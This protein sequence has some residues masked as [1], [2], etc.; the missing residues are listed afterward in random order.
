MRP[1]PWSPSALE[2]FKNCPSQYEHRYVLK[3]LPPEERSDEQVYGEYVHEAFANRLRPI[4]QPLPP[5]VKAHEPFMQEL[6]AQEGWAFVEHKAALAKTAE[7][8]EWSDKDV[9]CRMIIDYL[10]VDA[11]ERHATIVDH[12]TG[13][14]H[15]KFNQLVIY[16]L[17]TFQEFSYVDEIEVMFYWTKNRTTTRKTWKREQA[18]QLWKELAGDLRQYR[19][20]FRTGIWQVRPSGLCGGWCPVVGC[21]YW[22]PKR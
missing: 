22:R 8:C 11:R 19:D 4:R 3:D 10:R 9:W 15:Q 6:A 7:S 12:K 13:K 18:N 5:D 16:A 20:A 14:P 2:T 17:W 1:L 21:K